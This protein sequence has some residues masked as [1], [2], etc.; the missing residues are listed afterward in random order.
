MSTASKQTTPTRTTD[1]QEKKITWKLKKSEKEILAESTSPNNKEGHL[2]V[3]PKTY[4][5]THEQTARV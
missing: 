3:R 2:P 1:L 5:W 4:F